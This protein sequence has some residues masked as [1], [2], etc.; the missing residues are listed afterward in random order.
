MILTQDTHQEH[1]YRGVRVHVAG[2]GRAGA[3]L[4]DS[5]STDRSHGTGDTAAISGGSAPKSR[6]QWGEVEKT[7][8][9]G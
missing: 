3:K 4:I 6:R 5:E 7:V 1:L 9:R 2:G 8:K